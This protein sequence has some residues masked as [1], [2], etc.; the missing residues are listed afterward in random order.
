VRRYDECPARTPKKGVFR[1][2][3]LVDGQK[4]NMGY[5]KAFCEVFKYAM[6]F[7]D[8]TYKDT[9]YAFCVLR[10]KRLVGSIGCF[11]G[12]EVPEGLEDKI[13]IKDQ[14][15][16]EM[17]YKFKTNA[18]YTLAA[19]KLVQPSETHSDSIGAQ[20]QPDAMRSDA[21]Q[22][23]IVPESAIALELLEI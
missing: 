7:S 21:R 8:L 22:S 19:V 18:G 16:L 13:D 20:R 3:E 9:L 1:S 10:G 4:I 2:L 14:P 12:I 11:R 6:K 5:A 17:L 15:Y 23:A